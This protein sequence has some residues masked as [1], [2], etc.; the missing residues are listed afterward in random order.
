M[1]TRLLSLPHEQLEAGALVLLAFE[2]ENGGPPAAG[3]WLGDLYG[4]GEFKGK[5]LDTALLHRPAGLKAA[6]LLLVGGGR[7]AD[8]DAAG[9][10]KAAGAA[11]RLLKPKGVRT[12]GLVLPPGLAEPGHVSAA[13]EGALLG[14]YEPD[15]YKTVDA[16]EKKVV[17]SFTLLVPAVTPELEAAA[18]QGRI[19]ADSQ[20]FTRDLVS[21]PGNRLTPPVLAERAR[22]MA[23]EQ[24]LECEI[25]DRERMQQLGMGALLGVS[26][27][28]AEPPAFIIL[29]YR[30]DH[31][32][33]GSAHLGL[34]GK[35]IT[36]DTGGISIKPSENMDKMKYDMAG[37]AAVLGAM[38]ALAQLKPPVPVTAFVPAVEN[39]PGGRAQRPGD[40]VTTLSGKTVEVLNTDAEGRLI[41]A[42]AI[43]YAKRAGCTHLVDAAT[44]TGAIV[45]ALGSVYLGAFS[46]DDALVGR[47]MAAAGA[48]GEKMWR[49][50]IDDD[51]KEVLKSTFADIPNIGNRWGGA[52]T[53]SMFLKE[54]VESTP[55]VHLDIAGT[56]W[57]EEAKPFLAKGPSGVPVRSF[58]RLAMDWAGQ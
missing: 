18:R 36:F 4:S 2:K 25:L 53:A 12:I 1:D 47:V 19:V 7:Q 55:W 50:P 10:R 34:I 46:N 8:F 6:R 49:M 22:A 58:I 40:I 45:I 33:A 13:I 3:D 38:R 48:S 51:Y 41:L 39:M 24:G 14:D 30:P 35:G 29:R 43:T 5:P 20:N 17:E 15:R 31:P 52:I 11:L 54:F 37:G 27:G 23:A 56:A 28:S 44:L 57:L 9:L 16:A 32:A 21:E 26:A 42:D